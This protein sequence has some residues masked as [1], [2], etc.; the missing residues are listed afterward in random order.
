MN[1]VPTILSSLTNSMPLRMMKP[2]KPLDVRWVFNQLLSP[3]LAP[4]HFLQD[5]VMPLNPSKVP[6]TPANLADMIEPVD[7][8][9][10]FVITFPIH[11]I[12]RVS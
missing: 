12:P 4:A 8:M 10:D 5:F 6:V 11:V 2:A 9:L 3:A 7:L 1:P